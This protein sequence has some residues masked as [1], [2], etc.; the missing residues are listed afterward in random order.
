M[1]TV[2]WGTQPGRR[3]ALNV[4]S[5]CHAAPYLCPQQRKGTLWW[6]EH[7]AREE[8]AWPEHS[9]QPAADA[10][11][12]LDTYGCGQN[13]TAGSSSHTSV[14]ASTLH[15]SLSPHLLQGN[16]DSVQG[17]GSEQPLGSQLIW[18]RAGCSFAVGQAAASRGFCAPLG[19]ELF[20]FWSKCSKLG[21]ASL[22][23]WHPKPSIRFMKLARQPREMF[24][25]T[26]S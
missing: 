8:A 6:P 17:M 25:R 24:A 19:L 2:L 16:E 18:H 9:G 20:R 14:T 21:Y 22:L 10:M 4:E 15:L 13:S 11:N 3:H 1:P 7:H 12:P 23:L 26:W 5:S